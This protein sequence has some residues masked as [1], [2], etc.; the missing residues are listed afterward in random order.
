MSTF[1]LSASEARTGVLERC[2][3][4]LHVLPPDKPFSVTVEPYKKR[5]SLEQNAYLWGVCYPTIL[6]DGGEALRGWGAD[7]LHEFFLIKHFG[8][9]LIEGFGVKR[10]KPLKRSSKLSTTEFMDFV[11]CIQREAAGLGIFV[12]DP[13]PEWFIKEDKAA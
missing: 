13:D 5:R 3:R 10:H 4:F 2:V 8:S 1:I 12:P 9:E 6:R 7:D 11:A